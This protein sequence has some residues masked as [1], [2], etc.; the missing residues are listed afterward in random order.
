MTPGA[1]VGSGWPAGGLRWAPM[2]ATT[3]ESSADDALAVL[4]VEDEPDVARTLRRVIESC[5]AHRVDLLDR[6][7]EVAARLAAS[8]P[9]LVFTDLVMPGRDGFAVIRDVKEHDPDLPVVVVSAHS[10]LA[11]AVEAVRQG[12]FDFL[13]KP[14]SFE[15]VD[16]VLAKVARDRRLR[17]RMADVQS[18]LALSDPE[19]RAL[20]GDSPAMARLRDWVLRARGAKANVLIEGESGTGKELVARALHGGK[21]PFVAINMAAVPEAL[22]ESELFGYR[23]GAF[24]GA[25]TDHTGLIAQADGGTLF[26]DEVNSTPPALQAKLLR[27]LAERRVRPL[28]GTREQEVDLRLVCASNVDLEAL[29]HRGDFRRDLYHRIKVLHVVVP[30][31]RQRRQDI[32]LLADHFL[33]RYARSHA[34]AA[35]RLSPAAVQHLM[36]RDWPGNVREL[37]NAVEQAVILA[38]PR[39]A[40]LPASAFDDELGRGSSAADGAD[41]VSLDLVER[42]HI[43]LVLQHCG[44]NKAQAA[45]LLRIDYK[46][47]LRKLSSG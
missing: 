47:L 27:V 12:A 33:H 23:K 8:R 5:G 30:P 26:L 4:V 35:R 41:D 29:V 2:S 44:G 39:Q 37:E 40:I 15:S 11:N 43:R 14:F 22:A 13:P 46:T 6:A 38:D 34:S 21:G 19:I 42:R 10:T 36:Q 31:L 1:A 20:L 32:A 24:S 7:D 28:G 9:D 17:L 18:K 3:R 16:L 45:R 25:A